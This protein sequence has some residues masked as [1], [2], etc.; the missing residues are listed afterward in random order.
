[1]PTG[2][3]RLKILIC[4]Y[5]TPMKLTKKRYL[6]RSSSRLPSESGHRNVYLKR[7]KQRFRSA[8]FSWTKKAAWRTSVRTDGYALTFPMQ[9]VDWKFTCLSS[10]IPIWVFND[11][12]GDI[13]L[14]QLDAGAVFIYISDCFYAFGE[15]FRTVAHFFGIL[16]ELRRCFLGIRQALLYHLIRS[17]SL[18]NI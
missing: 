1:M 8:Q 6:W 11:G 17:D 10:F 18:V 15:I 12:N 9:M 13:K 2:Q 5:G 14:L 4:R 3:T 7:V 16:V